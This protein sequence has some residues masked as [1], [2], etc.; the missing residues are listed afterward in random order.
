MNET[1]I[2]NLYISRKSPEIYI[3]HILETLIKHP[4]KRIV[5]KGIGFSV[6]TNIISIVIELAHRKIIDEIPHS[7]L[8]LK[9]KIDDNSE[10]V[11]AI[12]VEIKSANAIVDED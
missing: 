12:S 2:I 4:D 11:I 7:D 6:V 5:L 10:K 3:G 8:Y 9:E 1:D